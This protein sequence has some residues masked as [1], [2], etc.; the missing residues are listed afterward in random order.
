MKK[1]VIKDVYKS[2]GP[3]EVICGFNLEVEEGEFVSLLGPSGCGKTT[4]LRMIAGLTLPTSGTIVINGQDVSKLPAYKRSN[5]M[6]FQN[7]ALFPHM[8]VQQNVAFGLRM[9]KEDKSTINQRVLEALDM[10]RLSGLEKRYPKELS[11]GQQQRV[12]LARALVLHPTLLLLDEPLSN[13]DAQLRKEM[14][15][16]IRQIQKR[17]NVAT[18]FVTHDQEEALSMSDRIAVINRGVLEQLG[19]PV[20]LYETPATQF[21]ASFIGS[22]NILNGKVVRTED[23]YLYADLGDAKIK[24]EN[25]HRA[26]V[27]QSVAISVRPERIEVTE[28]TRSNMDDNL[29]QCSILHRIY[30]GGSIRYITKLQCGDEVVVEVPATNQF[31]NLRGGD[32]VYLKW[33]ADDGRMVGVKTNK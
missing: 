20:D 11:G 32:R 1:L 29:V 7:Y 33:A 30:L 2:F 12:A 24:V 31:S 15:T 22:T 4:M 14:R 17:L 3:V 23:A 5:G 19:S 27:G 21:V 26:E 25:T 13:L 9:H 6:V 28:Q 10:V 18:I 8:T 16:E